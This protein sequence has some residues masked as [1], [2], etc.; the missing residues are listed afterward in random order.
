MKEGEPAVTRATLLVG[1]AETARGVMEGVPQA[2]VVQGSHLVRKGNGFTC[3]CMGNEADVHPAEGPRPGL[4]LMGGGQEIDVAFRWL[5]DHACGGD[6]VVL[7]A[8]GD[9]DYNPYMYT[10]SHVNKVETLV[11][12]DERGASD[13]FIVD[14]IARAEGI[15][16]AG[17]NQWDYVHMWRGTPL[18]QALQDA[19]ARGV[20]IG[21]TSAGLAIMGEYVF[22][23]ERD[24]VTSPEAMADPHGERMTV[25]H[26]ILELPFMHGVITDTHFAQ[27]DRMGRL[28]AF[29]ERL[30]EAHVETEARA[31][32]VDERTAVLVDEKGSGQ[33][34]GEG[35]AYF[36]H[37]RPEVADVTSE[38]HHCL[39]LHKVAVVKVVAGEQFDLTQWQPLGE[40][41]SYSLDAVDGKLVSSRRDGAVY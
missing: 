38:E 21:G 19:A 29:M 7:R 6:V 20:P 25:D 15:F 39:T 17:G 24:T 41:E 30:L 23:A 13:P 18:E 22:T 37:A 31:I 10:H 2:G 36:L 33:V 32:A 26:G 5:L 16:I 11:I 28:L 34:C 27:R 9:D 3:F 35:A 40:A 1:C 14:Q 12:E 8:K 4:M